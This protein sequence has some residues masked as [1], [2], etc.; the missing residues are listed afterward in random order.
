M[1]GNVVQTVLKYIVDDASV[2]KAVASSQ[3]VAT[4]NKAAASSVNDVFAK[5]FTQGKTSSDVLSA[6]LG[7][8]VK[9]V[10]D[11]TEAYDALEKQINGTADAAQKVAGSTGAATSSIDTFGLPTQQAIRTTGLGRLGNIL[12]FAGQAGLPGGR[13][14]SGAL[15]LGGAATALG[16]SLGEV[17]LAAGV[18]GIALGAVAL[19]FDAFDKSAQASK[20]TLDAAIGAQDI[21]YTALGE[22]TTAQVKDQI[23]GLKRS[24]PAL[25][26]QINETQKAIDSAFAQEVANFGGGALGDALAR[27]ADA[28]GKTPYEQLKKQLDELNATYES[29]RQ[30]LVRLDQG[31]ANDAF[32]L[33]DLAQQAEDA[34]KALD[35]AAKSEEQRRIA[36]TESGIQFQQQLYQLA[37]GGTAD[38]ATKVAQQLI[39][40]SDAISKSL[41]YLEKHAGD[42][43][44]AAQEFLNATDKIRQASI[45]LQRIDLDAVSAVV[46]NT[47]IKLA[48]DIAAI[49]AKEAEAEAIALDDKNAKLNAAQV[50]ADADLVKLAADTADK[51]AKIERT[52][53][54]SAAEAIQDRDA[55]ALDKARTKRDDDLADLKDATAKQRKTIKQGLKDQQDTI[56]LAY[57]KQL[58]TARKQAANEIALKNAAASASIQNLYDTLLAEQRLRDQANAAHLAAT[59]YTVKTEKALLAQLATAN[60]SM[61]DAQGNVHAVAQGVSYLTV[62]NYPKWAHDNGI[63]GFAQG[64]MVQR[65]GLI[66]AHKRELVLTEQQQRNMGGAGITINGY[67]M[68]EE[69]VVKQVRRALRSYNRG[70]R[71]AS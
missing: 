5:A 29:N 17:A 7:R 25:K 51:R 14:A 24:Q 13:E 70:L 50:K 9:T 37:A 27:A 69:Q 59:A 46:E 40:E 21:Y 53:A 55:V 31:L 48:A 57:Q 47:N 30:G 42:S 62:D 6:A 56:E 23:D 45:E 66:F 26:Q 54:R 18:A 33:N 28:A 71:A 12:R 43:D 61:I 8:Q 38:D 2:K 15:E 3:Q 67:G 68:N 10:E 63:P 36:A 49:N 20:R 60:N 58:T 34:S 19:A 1:P 39:Q 11:M 64:G 52:Y 41:G 35:A 16:S 22:S 4:A 44:A 32:H 65:T